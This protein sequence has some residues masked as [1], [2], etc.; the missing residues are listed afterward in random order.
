MCNRSHTR[1]L[2]ACGINGAQTCPPGE[3]S[4]CVLWAA[5]CLLPVQQLVHDG[6]AGPLGLTGP[7]APAHA[8]PTT[9][10]PPQHPSSSM[11][12]GADARAD[13]AAAAAL[14]DEL[15]EEE[16]SPGPAGRGRRGGAGLVDGLPSEGEDEEE[17]DKG[18][19]S[20][21]GG[22]SSDSSDEEEGEDAFEDDGFI[23]GVLQGACG[24]Q[25]G[26]PMR[27]GRRAARV[28]ACM[29]HACVLPGVL[30][31]G[32]THTRQPGCW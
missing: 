27:H 22:G 1:A 11:A 6:P 2:T 28:R 9:H 21:S 3:H 4:S 12:E 19:G 20:S 30:H 24:R 8:Q 10:P 17:E 16:P 29:G 14:E 13:E 7:P 32:A 23:A 26:A 18:E 25:A 31:P 5:Q 15:K